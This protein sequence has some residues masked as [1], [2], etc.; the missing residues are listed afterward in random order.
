MQVWK[1]GELANRTGITVRTLH[2]YDEIGLLTPSER[3]RSGYRLY[4]ERDIVRLQQ[5]LSLRHLG[6]SLEE[7]RTCLDE[8]EYT[9]LQVVELHLARVK[10]R[11]EEQQRLRAR[12]EALAAHLRSAEPI[13]AEEFIQTM[14]MTTMFEKYYTAEQLEELEERRRS[15]GEDRIRE[16]EAEWPRLIA[17]VRAEMEKGT[18]PADPRMQE[19][20]A[21][22]MAL[23]QEFTGGNAEIERSL[24]TMYEQETHVAGMDTGPMRE[25]GAYI[26]GAVAAGKQS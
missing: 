8:A 25:L 14:E 2:H 1:V 26:S 11:I 17:E 12:L 20:S 15:L 13:S 19:L 18:D 23:V 16:V 4:T 5:I 7:I 10:E 6:F 22:W 9:P 24:R 21:R 3:S